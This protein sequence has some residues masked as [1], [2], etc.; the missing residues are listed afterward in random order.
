MP[1]HKKPGR[2]RLEV[3]RRRCQVYLS[4]AVIASVREWKRAEEKRTL[5]EALDEM[6]GIAS[7]YATDMQAAHRLQPLR[8]VLSGLHDVA[9][10]EHIRADPN[11]GRKLWCRRC[12][13]RHIITSR[14][15][16][17]ML[18]QMAEFIEAHRHDD[19]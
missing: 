13:K 6:I 9:V 4:D 18:R 3:P 14:R 7:Y 17:G 11:T 8:S 16:S 12:Q 10:P 19:E 1:A 15:F 5:S 2:K